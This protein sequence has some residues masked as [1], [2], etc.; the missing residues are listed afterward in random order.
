VHE[1]WEFEYWKEKLVVSGQRLAAAVRKVGP[2]VK[3]VKEYLRQKK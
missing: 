1:V 2:M 3:N